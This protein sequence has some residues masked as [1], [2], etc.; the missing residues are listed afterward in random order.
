MF[1]F[2]ATGID[3][4]SDADRIYTQYMRVLLPDP[5]FGTHILIEQ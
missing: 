2:V 4:C 5:E 3:P 1:S